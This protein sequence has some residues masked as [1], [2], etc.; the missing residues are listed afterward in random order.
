MATHS[1]I[2]AWR[3]PWTEDE[4]PSISSKLEWCPSVNSPCP[5]QGACRGVSLGRVNFDLKDLMLSRALGSFARI[6]GSRF[7]WKHAV[8]LPEG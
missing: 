3:I 5:P 4:K 7:G 6:L 1:T 2:L 8:L